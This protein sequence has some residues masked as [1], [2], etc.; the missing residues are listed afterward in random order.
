MT[1]EDIIGYLNGIKIGNKWRRTF[2]LL[3]IY[4]TRFFR[5]FYHPGLSPKERNETKPQ[6]VE[7]LGKVKI[8]TK[9]DRPYKHTVCGPWRIRI[10]FSNI[11]RAKK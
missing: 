10:Y 11:A 8:D 9:K 4:L 6:V 7:N 1:R 5:W 3:C 2:K